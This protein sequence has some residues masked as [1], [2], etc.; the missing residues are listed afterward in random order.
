MSGSPI[1]V[2]FGALDGAA[3][4][5]RNTARHIASQLTEL[6]AAVVRVTHHWE[7]LAEDGYRTRQAE[8]DRSAADLNQVLERIGA[9]LDAAGQQYAGTEARNASM[10]N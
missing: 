3:A 2:R 5:C 6:R 9:A 7:G 1:L 10:W 4:D 8:W